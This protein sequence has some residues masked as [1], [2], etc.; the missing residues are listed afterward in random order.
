MHRI[1][2][3]AALFWAAPAVA[4]EITPGSAVF[5]HSDG[6]SIEHW[7]AAR[8]LTA[9]PDGALHWDSLPR[10]GVYTG[11]MADLLN[12]TSNGGATTHAYGIKVRARSYGL[13]GADTITAASGRRESIAEEVLAAGLRLG[14]VNTGTITE[15]GTG[16]FVA[17]VPDRYQH[18]AIALQILRSGA[19]VLLGGGERYFLPEGVR[20]RHAASGTRTDGL[21][22][23]DSARA[24]GYTLVFSTSELASLPAGTTRVLGLFADEHTFHDEPEETL[25]VRSLP[26]YMAQAPSIAAMVSAALKILSANGARFLLVAEEE[27]TDNLAN[28]NHAA[29]T[30]EATRR[31][32][33]AIGVV[34]AFLRVHPS[35]L[36]L[37][38]ADSDA[39]GLSVVGVPQ[40]D[41][42]KP[43][44]V[45]TG[46]GA[47]M[48]GARGT[49]SIPFLAAP[50]RAG[51]RLPFGICWST[52]DDVAGS[53]LVRAEGHGADAVPLTVD[54]TGI[55]K[56]LY[57]ALFGRLLP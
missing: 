9:G 22:L 37:V 14:L 24:W 21:N 56:L 31:A 33:E 35:T 12:G 28:A 51:L 2:L 34:R 19:Q 50:D 25:R 45:R 39:G 54:N 40:R 57:R 17:R 29:G 18:E 44:P 20:G 26:V 5:L 4:A 47:P 1:L 36:L 8:M 49:G 10:M 48:D 16:A 23:V 43:L 32:D 53:V 42:E 30:L 46:N 3:V 38:A 15:P 55:Y 52:T 11:H 7:A 6:T 41:A 27:G 13:D